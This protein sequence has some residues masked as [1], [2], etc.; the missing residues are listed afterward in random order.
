MRLQIFFAGF[1]LFC[2]GCAH[3]SGGFTPGAEPRHGA[4]GSSSTQS[5][6]S[7]VLADAPAQYFPLNESSGPTAY[8]G[9]TTSIN[10]TYVGGVTFGVSGPLLDEPSTAIA[11]PGGA[12]SAGVRLPAPP[13]NTSGSYSLQ[14]W[15][16]PLP[17]SSYMTIWGYAGNRRL[18]LSATGL[19]LT[20]FDGNYFSKG[21]LSRNQWHDVVFV[22]NAATQTAAYYI[23]GSEDSTATIPR[24]Y[25]AFTSAYYL[26]QYSTGTYYRWHGSLAQ[27]ALYPSALTPSQIE[28]LHAAAGYA[29]SPAPTATPTATPIPTPTPTASPGGGP[30]TVPYFTSS[31]SYG[32]KTYTYK[33]IGSD[34]SS[35]PA[36]TTIGVEI[37]PVDLQFSNGVSFDASSAAATIP[38]TALFQNA[39]YAAG[40]TQYGDAFMRSEFW[41]YASAGDYHV[42]LGAPLV[43]PTQNIMVPSADGYTST[44]SSGTEGYVTYAWFVQTIEPQIIQQLRINPRT[45]TIF[46]TVNT[47]VLEPGGYCCY[48]G[49]HSAHQMTT[50]WGS[51]IA[52]TAWA[53]VGANSV[54]TLSHEIGEWLDDP[55]YTNVVPSWLNPISHGCN[56]DLL[57]VGDPV[58][59]YEFT[60]AGTSL[61]DLVYYSW[62]SRDTPSIGINGGYD[63]MN[64]LPAPATSC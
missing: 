28:A 23:D 2:V 17:S 27:H 59:N 10:G 45:L 53:S 18:L 29:P 9:S 62:F 43:E 13:A 19:L 15:V 46:A 3:Q 4:L 54:E 57:E 44:N 30:V 12:A 8:D 21:T 60:A 26:G 36:A 6:A 14:T 48:A 64:K 61:Q 20:Q 34:P 39:T 5:Y 11:V 7:A 55:F 58:T 47:K 16:Y 24:T 31:F 49:Y 37:V 50:A 52:T 35:A 22:Y 40:T 32:G 33:M 56:G 38:Q 25:A 1:L 42:L 63:L 51:S 41:K